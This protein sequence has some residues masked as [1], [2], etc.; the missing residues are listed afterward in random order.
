MAFNRRRMLVA[1]GGLALTACSG[2]RG[3]G[4]ETPTVTLESFRLL[5]SEGLSPRFLIGLRVVNP[6]PVAIDLRGISYDVELE[7]RK[8][9][10]GVAG[11]L[12]RVP[13][14]AESQIELQAGVDLLGSIRLLNDLMT[15]ASR[16]RLAYIFRARLDIAGLPQRLTLEESGELTLFGAGGQ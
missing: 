13:P 8:L 3:R 4:F 15:D 11:N 6:N 5:P 1:L 16:D 2:I 10:S 7:G 12:A 9:L 14:Y